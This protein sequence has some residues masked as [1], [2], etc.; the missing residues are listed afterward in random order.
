M[1]VKRLMSLN[2]HFNSGVG[3]LVAED[4]DP[5]LLA[6]RDEERDRLRKKVAILPLRER[7]ALRLRYGM[8]G[9]ELTLEELGDR[10]GC[11][12]ETAR[13]RVKNAESLLKEMLK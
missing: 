5:A 1:T 9:R 11:S 8:D 3:G 10:L 12:R 6:A 4:V 13:K 7:K 2:D